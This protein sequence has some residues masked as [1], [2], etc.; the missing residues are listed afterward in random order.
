MIFFCKYCHFHTDYPSQW[1][2]H[3]SRKRH[4]KRTLG[5]EETII[6][7]DRFELLKK[8][9]EIRKVAF[10][11]VY[12]KVTNSSRPP[13]GSW[14]RNELFVD[15]LRETLVECPWCHDMI[16]FNNKRHVNRHIG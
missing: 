4:L 16:R 10:N 11:E 2:I 8:Y 14:S 13:S 9:N 12:K 7:Q 3:K 5:K 6:N 1:V 15:K